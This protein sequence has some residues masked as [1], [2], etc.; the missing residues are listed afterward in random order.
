MEEFKIIKVKGVNIGE[1]I[2][3]SLSTFHGNSPAVRSIRLQNNNG[4]WTISN[5]ITYQIHQL[6]NQ[7]LFSKYYDFAGIYCQKTDF[8]NDIN[9]CLKNI[10]FNAT[11]ERFTVNNPNYKVYPTKYPQ[12]FYVNEPVQ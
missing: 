11:V 6:S 2:T 3:P 7:L 8:K 5:Y 9:N 12:G 4:N 1:Y 10:T